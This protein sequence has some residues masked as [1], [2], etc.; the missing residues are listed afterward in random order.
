MRSQNELIDLPINFRWEFTR[1]HPYYLLFWR[2]ACSYW[3]PETTIDHDF[4]EKAFIAFRMLQLIGVVGEPAD[5][6][7][8]FDQ[9]SDYDPTLIRGSMQPM[10]LRHMV[11]ILI[12][13]LPASEL[14]AISH[15]LNVAGNSEFAIDDDTDL[16]RQKYSARTLLMR[17]CSQQLDSF[18]ICPLYYIHMDASQRRIVEDV[19][20]Q[21]RHWKARRNIPDRRPR[22]NEFE[23][24]LRI[25]DAR[26]GWNEGEYLVDMEQTFEQVAQRL[27]IPRSTAV[28]GY[29]SAFHR[30]VGHRFSPEIWLQVMGQVKLPQWKRD[31]GPK[32]S[33][34][35]RRILTQPGPK[36]AP[37]T[38]IQS[39]QPKFGG[40]GLVERESAINEHQP[41]LDLLIDAKEL[42]A[43]R[44]S[45]EAIAEKLD[46]EIS[47]IAYLRRQLEEF[48]EI[49]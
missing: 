28:A 48:A 10:T 2:D 37:E 23:D 27:G 12:A 43:R 38:R 30:I 33:A 17:I 9:L 3:H 47:D 21:V 5:P 46:V 34:R 8:A 42:L 49:R 45:D 15:V 13:A 20:S 36:P 16:S 7:K 40:V 35:Y 44:L 1:R 39:A 24:Y 6:A 41:T 11:D 14:C 22:V 26:E 29:R 31:A 25:W 4:A 32:L 18:P 19:E